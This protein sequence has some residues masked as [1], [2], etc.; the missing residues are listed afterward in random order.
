MINLPAGGSITRISE[1]VTGYE[2]WLIETNSEK[3][4][5]GPVIVTDNLVTIAAQDTMVDIDPILGKKVFKQGYSYQF[6]VNPIYSGGNSNYG[7]STGVLVDTSLPVITKVITDDFSTSWNLQL[8]WDGH[9]EL[10]GI[11]RVQV[12]VG[13][14]PYQSNISKGWLDIAGSQRAGR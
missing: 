10:S 6:K 14:S 9:D 2:L 12:A 13:T 7:Y 5:Y 11:A 8:T 1:K 3:V 4:I